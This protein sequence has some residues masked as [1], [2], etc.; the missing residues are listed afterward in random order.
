MCVFN[1]HSRNHIS[2]YIARPFTFMLHT[3]KNSLTLGKGIPFISRSTFLADEDSL[4]RLI[5]SENFR[6]RE[7]I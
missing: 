6:Y 1:V 3:K 4:K 2:H 7:Y 5:Y